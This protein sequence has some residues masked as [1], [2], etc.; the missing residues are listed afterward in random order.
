MHAL[1]MCI[2]TMYSLYTCFYVLIIH[3]LMCLG[4]TQLPS[5]L[6]TSYCRLH[7]VYQPAAAYLFI[8]VCLSVRLVTYEATPPPPPCMSVFLF[9]CLYL[10]LHVD[11]ESICLKNTEYINYNYHM[12]I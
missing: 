11:S 7:F 4:A 5:A 9:F 10:Y 2:H 6:Q 12:I 3:T 1:Y 8:C